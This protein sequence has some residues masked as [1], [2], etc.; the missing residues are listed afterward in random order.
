MARGR[1]VISSGSS[2]NQLCESSALG[3][4][5]SSGSIWS[6]K[7]RKWTVLQ[8]LCPFKAGTNLESCH[9]S[10]RVNGSPGIVPAV[11]NMKG[12]QPTFGI[13]EFSGVSG[14]A[15]RIFWRM[16]KCFNHFT[17]MF[18]L[19][20][21]EPACEKGCSYNELED[22]DHLVRNVLRDLQ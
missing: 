22:L 15:Y 21:E 3:L 5:R 1:I 10:E 16:A 7:R 20:E 6:M 8:R 4:P 13:E 19:T 18:S 17:Q 11:S 9:S 12:N 14:C 2:D